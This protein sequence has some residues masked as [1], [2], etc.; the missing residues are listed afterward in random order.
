MWEAIIVN[1]IGGMLKSATPSI[2][3]GVKKSLDILEKAAKKTPNKVDDHL[4]AALKG[5]ILGDVSAVR[6]QNGHDKLIT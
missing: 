1:L 5:I 4:I 2:R 6:K 3:V